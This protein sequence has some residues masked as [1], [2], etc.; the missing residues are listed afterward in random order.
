MIDELTCEVDTK[1]QAMHTLIEDTQAWRSR[2]EAS[3][4]W[5]LTKP[6]RIIIS[7]LANGRAV[8]RAK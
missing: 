3:W 1:A 7:R 2:L 5:K 8:G 6:L 4:S